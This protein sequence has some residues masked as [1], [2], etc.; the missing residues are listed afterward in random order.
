M[1]AGAPLL[2]ESARA[3]D[4]ERED[5][6]AAGAGA[7]E[8]LAEAPEVL[9]AAGD[10]LRFGGISTEKNGW[11]SCRCVFERRARAHSKSRITILSRS[12]RDAE[13]PGPAP[14]L[15]AAKRPGENKK[16]NRAGRGDPRLL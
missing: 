12:N 14:H 13:A 1:A 8:A 11:K 9:R 15:A 4:G 6:A 3:G 5:G 7:A 2:F 16:S 10:A